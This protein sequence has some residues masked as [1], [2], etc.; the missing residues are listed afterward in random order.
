MEEMNEIREG[1]NRGT[2][3]RFSAD[4]LYI[5]NINGRAQR[6]PNVGEHGQSGLVGQNSKGPSKFH[7]V[8]LSSKKKIHCCMM[9]PSLVKRTSPCLIIH[10]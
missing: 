1:G 9:V 2:Q 10:G 8:C 4:A 5:R 7:I 6:I 3:K